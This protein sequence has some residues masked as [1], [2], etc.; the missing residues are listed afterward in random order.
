MSWYKPW[1]WADES[2][3]AGQQRKD[4]NVQGT[5]AGNFAD[6]GE[7]GF[8]ALGAEGA[9]ARGYLRDLAMGKNSLSAEQLRQ[10]LQQQLGMQQSMA[11]G[12]PSS[13]APM[14]ARTAMT[15]AGRASSAMAGN[16]AMAGIAERNA[17]Q[18]A[19]NQAILGARGQDLQAALGSRQNAIG[20]YGAVTPDKSTL[21]KWGNAVT[22]AAGFGAGGGGK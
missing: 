2:Q 16:A 9:E 3:S 5:S 17:A 18:Q 8:G 15:G 12:A 4:L 20:A 11:A 1:T 10:G 14:A 19:W 7:K 22:T 21:D 6:Q 13:S